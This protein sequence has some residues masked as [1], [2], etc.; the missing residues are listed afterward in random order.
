MTEMMGDFGWTD[1]NAVS[2]FAIGQGAGG[3]GQG[4]DD[5]SA[6]W[7]GFLPLDMGWNAAGFG[8]EGMSGG[9]GEGELGML[10]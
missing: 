4:Q 1:L 9:F 10:F 5:A 8:F 7:N 3:N 6:L 2:D